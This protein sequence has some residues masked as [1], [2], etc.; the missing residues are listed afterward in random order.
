MLH[1]S[2]GEFVTITMAR[3]ERRNALSTDMLLALSD[4][5]R[6]AGDSGARGVVLAAEGPAFSAGHDLGELA[7]LDE[8]GMR[9][10]FAIC[11][12]TMLA[13]QRIPQPVVA[14]VP[15]PAFAAGC[16]LVAA[17]DL[18]VA[19]DTATFAAPGGKGG[20]FCHTPMVAIGRAVGFK[21]GLEM[22][23]T[24]DAID[25]PTALE[26]GLVNRVVPAADLEAA[27]RELLGRATR[28]SRTSKGIGKQAYYAQMSMGLDEAYE[29]ATDVMARQ[30]M[31]P[32]ALEW[33]RAFVEKRE[34][35]FEG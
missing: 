35:K 7:T 27:T 23:L 4:A 26:W 16:Q 19:A 20:L 8:A 24:G 12:E 33:Y 21:H 31:H 34:A 22:A 32:A 25:A 18:A 3:P 14:Q 9:K 2:D 28:G 11:A 17:C 1:Y 13:I 30:A 6:K 5:F 29:Y 10:L 15:G